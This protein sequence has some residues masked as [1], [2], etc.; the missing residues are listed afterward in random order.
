MQIVGQHD[1]FNRFTW[2]PSHIC[3]SGWQA[4]KNSKNRRNNIAAKNTQLA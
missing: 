3:I 2:L 1:R 4:I